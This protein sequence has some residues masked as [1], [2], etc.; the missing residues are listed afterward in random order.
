MKSSKILI[1]L[2]L[3]I[4][5]GV[6]VSCYQL[7]DS[8]QQNEFI[9]GNTT[10]MLPEGYYEEI[11]NVSDDVKITNGTNALFLVEYNDSNL[12]KHINDYINNSEINN[13]SLIGSN[14]TIDNLV[15]YKIINNQTGSYHFWFVKDKKVYLVYTW[16][17]N[18]KI[19]TLF[20]DLIKSMN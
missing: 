2:I 16:G 8:K 14:F 19:D 5:I 1:I 12:T 7:V 13:D 15:V 18:N 9:V 20:F 4:L 11:N 17:K 3:L 10:F 6:S